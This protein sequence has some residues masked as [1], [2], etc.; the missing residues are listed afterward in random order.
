MIECPQCGCNDVSE[1]NPQACGGDVHIRV[2][3]K[4]CF[5]CWIE[6]APEIEKTPP[7]Y[8]VLLC[9]ECGGGMKVNGTRG[10]ERNVQCKACGRSAR[11]PEREVRV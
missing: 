11:L 9:V 2:Q 6:R 1:G 4:H 5:Y 3:C 7:A 10:G 8:Q